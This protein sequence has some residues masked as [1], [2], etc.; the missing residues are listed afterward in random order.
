M[1]WSRS[2]ESYS[3]SDAMNTILTTVVSILVVATLVWAVKRRLRLA[4]CPICVGVG[5]T[6]LWMLIARELGL[7]IDSEMLAILLGGST[8]AIA[9]Q[10][11]KRLPQGRSSLLWKTVF[12]PPGFV[13][14]Y[15]LVRADW[16]LF[17]ATAFCLLLLSGYLL[18]APATA[19]APSA[20]VEDLKNRMKQCC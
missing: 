9:S 7:A 19:S 3:R 6:W 17:A 4:L 13:A 10:V 16:L 11:D 5:A 1:P 15:A 14:A 18:I 2:A 8:V 12:L 20:Q